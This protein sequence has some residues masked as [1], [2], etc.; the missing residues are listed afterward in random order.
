M[1]DVV[2]PFAGWA[3]PD[4]SSSI[5]GVGRQKTGTCGLRQWTFALSSLTPGG[6]AAAA[7]DTT[8]PSFHSFSK[9]Q[10][11]LWSTNM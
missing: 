8:F 11:Y 10:R 1:E 3:R 6:A 9:I 2:I 7:P 4:V 5:P